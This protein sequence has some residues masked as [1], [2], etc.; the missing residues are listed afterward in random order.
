MTNPIAF[1][2][3]ALALAC[4]CPAVHGQTVKYEFTGGSMT[5]TVSGLPSGVTASNFSIGTFTFAALSDNGGSGN[6]LR[7]S[8]GD[9]GTSSTTALAGPVLSFTLTI[10]AGV[11][12]NLTSLAIDFTS[13]GVTTA[14]YINARVFSS[15]D[16]YDDLTADTIGTLGRVANGADSGTMSV[17]LTTPD[18]N[19][20]NGGNSNNGDFDN[21]SNRTVTFYLPFIRDG[22]TTATDFLDIDNITLSF[23]EPSA[24]AGTITSFAATAASPTEISLSWTE[25]ISNETGFVIERSITGADTWSTVTTT[26][27]NATSFSDATVVS[28]NAYTY[29]I[30]AN[31]TGGGESTPV[32]SASVSLLSMVKF[33]FTGGSTTPS[34]TLM[35]PGV[36]V[37]NISISSGL[38][39]LFD[40]NGTPDAP[41]I[42]G[43]DTQ[44]TTA[45]ALAN[46]AYL[47]FSITIPDA[48]Y[49]KL[50]SLG[51][52][53]QATNAYARSSAQV[54]TSIDG[55]D[56]PDSDAIGLVGRTSS[57]SDASVVNAVLSLSNPSSNPG[58]GSNVTTSDF[59]AVTN[60]TLTFHIPW[61]DES[62][63][64]TRWTDV[65]NIMLTFAV[66]APGVSNFTASPVSAFET[67][68]A[69]NESLSDETGFIIE[70]SVTGSGVWETVITTAA[71]VTS[72]RDLTMAPGASYTYRISAPRSG[73]GTSP[74]VIS[75]SVAI[76]AVPSGPLVI[77]PMGDSITQGAGAG[78]G[79]RS[80]LYTSLSGAA[81]QLQYIGSRTDAPTTILT[82]AGQTHHEGHGSYSTDLL[83][84]NLDAN[85]PYGGTD[86]GGYWIT[87]GGGTGRAAVYPDLILL[88][89]GT[90]DIGMW[91]H[92][93]AEAIAYYD[94]LLTKLVTLRPSAR[95][96]CASIVPFVL[97][98]FEEAYPD[99]I[100]VYTNR[101][102]NNV[103]YN[104]MLPGL[105]ATH[106]AA[107]HRVQ[108]Y[109]MRQKVNPA[110]AA[111]LI[112]GDGVHPNQAGY[113]AIASGWF[114][115]MKQL[116][117]L[118]SWRIL[119]FGSA[120]AS[121]I[122][123]DL[124]DPDGDGDSN[125][126][127]YAFGTHPNSNNPR[128]VSATS[129]TD[130]GA[131]YLAI[132]F[133]RRKHADVRYIV[134]VSTD[135][136][137][138][139]ADTQQSGPPASLN[140]DMEQVTFRDRQ[141]SSI[142]EKRFMRVRIARP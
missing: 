19:P 59:N 139:S 124:A 106:Q 47:S 18:S 67:S 25:T 132:T 24:P 85:K 45:A 89:I 99:K 34:L 129:I 140:Q 3:L 29:R 72:I 4:A 115:A 101:E 126:M 7:L 21:L 6:S 141:T 97:S 66:G 55:Y 43:D 77:M 51:L 15:I 70:R 142:H 82:N 33:E 12:I 56:A 130:N 111:T 28:G 88:M 68:L 64:N 104:G 31:L 94:Q 117:L 75:N 96:I 2:S 61:I 81:F 40:N 123:A 108:F 105:V 93:P 112:G 9:L 137:S 58:V 86:E 63:S 135:L 30:K 110:N 78:G 23:V 57:G 49:L 11:T 103:I 73:G 87:G 136:L 128:P 48:T 83:L 131:A 102:A 39:N 44:N 62:A 133:P 14:E 119:H 60:R 125:L 16:G 98:E 79:Y 90:N 120:T 80:P 95:I 54:F 17:S 118:D 32:N 113:N 53:Y 50:L 134:E 26:T 5:P 38:G 138:W 122:A 37:S 84:G 27:A 42:S 52:D 10:P 69:W 8:R 92:T 121:G 91:A 1:V 35:P 116:P 65:D 76:P 20:T 127:E 114:D 74:A 41:R 100:G 36:T 22:Q 46:N 107:G 109:D 71:D 13:G